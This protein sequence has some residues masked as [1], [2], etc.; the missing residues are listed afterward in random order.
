MAQ[1]MG[2][3]GD[4]HVPKKNFYRRRFHNTIKNGVSALDRNYFWE[5][6]YPLITEGLLSY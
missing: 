4:K 3:L 1:L 2:E 6:A 5:H